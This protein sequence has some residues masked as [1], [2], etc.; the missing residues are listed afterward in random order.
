[1]ALY[2]RLLD[3]DDVGPYFDDVDMPK[4]MD[5]QTKFVS[6]LMG[7]PASFSDAHIE[8]A[9]QH[10]IVRDADFDRLKELVDATLSDFNLQ[11]VDIDTVLKSFED[12]RSLLVRPQNVD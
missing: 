5:H 12:R 6:A 7:G 3:D 4:L 9:H 10:L 11:R 1:M 2:E 8:R